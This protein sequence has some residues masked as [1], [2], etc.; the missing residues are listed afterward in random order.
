MS[1]STLLSHLKLASRASVFLDSMRILQQL[2][3]LLLLPL[4]LRI[5]A[6]MLLTD[7]DVGD[8]ALMGHAFQSILDVRAVVDLVEF[9]DVWLHAHFAEEGLGGFAVWAVGF[10]EDGCEVDQLLFMLLE[11]GQWTHQRHSRR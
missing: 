4:Q 6:N 3:Q 5:A 1:R 11:D 10:G 8:G 2:R 9:D 7:E